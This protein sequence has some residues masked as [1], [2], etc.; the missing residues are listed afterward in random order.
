M[1]NVGKDC[2]LASA[3]LLIL[4]INTDPNFHTGASLD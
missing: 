3:A 1:H 2:L 4:Y